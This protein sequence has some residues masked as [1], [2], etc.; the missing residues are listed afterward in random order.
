MSDHRTHEVN[1]LDLIAFVLRW[2]VFLITAV[3]TVSVVVAVI[4]FLLPLRY[5]SSAMIRAAEASSQGISGILA[6]K[7]A[8]LGGIGGFGSAFGEVPGELYVSIL[9][10]RWMS[11]NAITT[12]KLRSVYQM[13]KAPIEEVIKMFS[14]RTSY[15]LDPLSQTIVISADDEDPNRA[16]EMSTFLVDALDQRNAELRSMSARRQR[17]FLEQRLNDARAY[18]TNLEDSLTRFQLETGILSL[19]EQ[20]KVTI[21]AAATLEAQRLALESEL[22]MYRQLFAGR[23]TESEMIRLRI[24]GIDSSL[25]QLASKKFTAERDFDFLLHLKD[26]PDQG[27]MFLRLKRDIEV[28]QLLVAILLQQYEQ[29]R[30]DEKRDTPTLWRI[31]PPT[32]ATKRIWPRRSIMVGMAAF[33]TFVFGCVFALILESIRNASVDPSHPQHHRLL[34]IRAAFRK[35]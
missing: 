20:V 32:L 23:G 28:Q 9:K 35:P 14:A 19:D 4:S 25:R 29:A 7:F 31:D 2:R 11:E 13:E 12:L 1:L 24:A 15:E 34:N 22:A 26:V 33:G 21:G 27:M 17:E 18:L 30:I 16:Q 8:G 6:S 3:L 10:S 5:R